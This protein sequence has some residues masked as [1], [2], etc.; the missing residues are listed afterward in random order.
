MTLT[1]DSIR[2]CFDGAIPGLIATCSVDGVPNVSYVSEVHYMDSEHLALT[3]QFFSKTRENGWP[4]R[5]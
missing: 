1:I 3:F 5:S 2:D 4:T